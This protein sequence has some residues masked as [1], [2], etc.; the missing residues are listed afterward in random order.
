VLSRMEEAP[1]RQ[2]PWLLV[3]TLVVTGAACMVLPFVLD[4]PA[5]ISEVHPGWG[6]LLLAIALAVA[7]IRPLRPSRYPRFLALV[8]VC[9]VT[10]LQLDLFMAAAPSYDMRPASRFIADAQE[11]GREVAVLAR[12]HGQFG[13]YGRLVRPLDQLDDDTLQD[14]VKR[15]PQGYLILVGKRPD[16]YPD[17]VYT[18]P[19]RGRYLAILE[20][21]AVSDNPALLH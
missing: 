11:A 16:E 13:F 2:R 14:W 17:A 15:H 6:G 9:V 7:W 1:V 12:Y 8:S 4:K 19:Y 3:V 21:R 5:W 10:V 18:Q 20:G